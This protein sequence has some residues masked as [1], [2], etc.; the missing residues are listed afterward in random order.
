MGA[1]V[2]D[3]AWAEE[4]ARRIIEEVSGFSTSPLDGRDNVEWL[5]ERLIDLLDGQ[6]KRIEQTPGY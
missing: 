2:I 4:E 5:K 1:A 6:Q 3:P